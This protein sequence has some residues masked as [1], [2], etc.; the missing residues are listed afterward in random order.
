MINKLEV[1]YPSGKSKFICISIRPKVMEV[2]RALK[3]YYRIAVYTA[4]V[5]A[6]ADTILDYLDPDKEI[7]EARY[8][9]DHCLSILNVHVKDLRL[10]TQA[11]SKNE[12]NWTFDEFILVDNASHSFGFHIDNGYPILPY[13]NDKD[14]R[15][16]IHLYHFFK[17]MAL[18]YQNQGRKISSGNEIRKNLA[19]IKYLGKETVRNQHFSSINIDL[20]WT[21]LS[22]EYY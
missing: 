4:S 15:E 17:S 20:G 18:E 16:M 14:D 22:P 2:L 5:K 3:K 6:Y 1:K 12:D 21:I 11:N 10:F 19:K 8:Y 7:F 13:Y 9:R